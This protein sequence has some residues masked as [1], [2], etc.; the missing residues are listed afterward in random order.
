MTQGTGLRQ[1]QREAFE[2]WMAA[3]EA[4]DAAYQTLGYAVAH[5]SYGETRDRLIARAL[6]AVEVVKAAEAALDAADRDGVPA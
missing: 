5:G 6:A 4:R 2:A 1:A 3:R